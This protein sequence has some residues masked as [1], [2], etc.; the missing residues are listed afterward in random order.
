MNKRKLSYITNSLLCI[1]EAITLIMYMKNNHTLSLEYYTMDSNLLTLLSS[2]LFIIFY[3]KKSEFVKDFRFI[4]TCCLT[5]T[6]L[7][8]LLILAPMLNFNYKGLLL[9]NELLFLHTICPLLSIMSYVFFE[10]KSNKN[11]LGIAFTILYSLILIPLNILGLMSGPYPFLKVRE[12]SIGMS[13]IWGIIIIGGSYL[14]GIGLNAMNK[15]Y[16]KK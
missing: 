12:Q 8:V 1:L 16:N 14:I 15:I 5:V 9:E 2:F 3:K 4:T 7:V 11:Y 13:L 10:E 6:F